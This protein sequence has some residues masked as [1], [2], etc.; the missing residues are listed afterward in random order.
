MSDIFIDGRFNTITNKWEGFITFFPITQRFKIVKNKN[1][2][3][4]KESDNIISLTFDK[5]GEKIQVNSEN[6]LNLTVKI[7][8]AEVAKALSKHKGKYDLFQGEKDV[9]IGRME[10]DLN[11]R[12]TNEGEEMINSAKKYEDSFK[13]PIIK[14]RENLKDIASMHKEELKDKKN[15]IVVLNSSGEVKTVKKPTAITQSKKKVTT[16]N[17][18]IAS[19]ERFEK[20]VKIMKTNANYYVGIGVKAFKRISKFYPTESTHYNIIFKNS[21]EKILLEFVGDKS[22]KEGIFKINNSARCWTRKIQTNLNDFTL[23]RLNNLYGIYDLCFDG[24]VFYLDKNSRTDV[25]T[26]K[27][28]KEPIKESKKTKAE[29]KTVIKEPKKGINETAVKKLIKPLDFKENQTLLDDSLNVLVPKKEEVKEGAKEE[30]SITNEDYS[31]SEELKK[32]IQ[33]SL[34]RNNRLEEARTV[35]KGLQICIE[36][37]KEINRSSIN[38]VINDL[39]LSD[40]TEALTKIE[41]LN[42]ALNIVDE[43]KRS[44]NV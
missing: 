2:K 11:K 31:I 3:V 43:V 24:K 41:M 20:T 16:T 30:K 15:K 8:D 13:R 23:E 1:L 10:F 18:S 37:Y 38:D 22:T 40:D 29:E 19:V 27:V 42:N 4:R 6:R 33:F 32:E 21:G 35:A 5:S 7:Y 34:M 9:F 14:P 26:E 28:S 12:I 36:K 25:D 39:L 44:G 17:N